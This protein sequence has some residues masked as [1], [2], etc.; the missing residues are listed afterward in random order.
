MLV[1]CTSERYNQTV[2]TETERHNGKPNKTCLRCCTAKKNY[3][4]EAQEKR[5]RTDENEQ[6]PPS[7]TTRTAHVAPNVST[8]AAPSN[9][10]P[11][12]AERGLQEND[13]DPVSLKD[14]SRGLEFNK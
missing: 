12:T 5:K 4:S 10:V 13:V 3:K 2:N 8:S 6:V 7:K 14:G 1:P 9:T 11:A